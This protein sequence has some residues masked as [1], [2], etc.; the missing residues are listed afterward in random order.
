MCPIDEDPFKAFPFRPEFSLLQ[1]HL[2]C[3]GKN[4][5]SGSFVH[6]RAAIQLIWKSDAVVWHPS[7]AEEFLRL[8]LGH[9]DGT[10]C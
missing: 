1:K 5:C 2:Y 10:G 4:I 3:A 6:R 7:G 9:L 8:Q